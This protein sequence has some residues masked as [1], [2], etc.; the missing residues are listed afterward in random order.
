MSSAITTLL[1][2]LRRH[3]SQLPV[4]VIAAMKNVEQSA[5]PTGLNST[6]APKTEDSL[7]LAPK[8]KLS[9]AADVLERDGDEYGVAADIRAMIA[10]SPPI[11]KVHL[12]AG[13]YQ[14]VFYEMRDARIH[15]L[16][17]AVHEDDVLTGADV[18]RVVDQYIADYVTTKVKTGS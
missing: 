18:D 7:V 8:W 12:D 5:E 2:E 6:P 14:S 13:R 11:S 10:S 17:C 3:E 4:A 1:A 9:R 15:D 16:V